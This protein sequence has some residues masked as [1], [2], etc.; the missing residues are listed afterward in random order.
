MRS[1]LLAVVALGGMT[2]RAA[3]GQAPPTDSTSGW[4]L[5]ITPTR[6]AR[7]ATTDGTW[8]SLDVAPDGRRIVFDLVGQLY[9]L[10]ITGGTAHAITHGL[11]WNGQPRFSPD[12]AR[13]VFTSDRSGQQNLWTMRPD[14][15]DAHQLTHSTWNEGIYES[16]AWSPDGRSV[17]VTKVTGNILYAPLDLIRVD[18]ATGAEISV[19]GAMNDGQDAYLGAAFAS[20]L[21]DEVFVVHIRGTSW[22]GG[23]SVE[24]V[25]LNLRT[26]FEGAVR[27]TR[28]MA[29][30]AGFRPAVSHDGHYLAYATEHDSGATGVCLLDR[31]TGADRRLVP[32]ASDHAGTIWAQDLF[33][34][35]AF[36]PDN[37]A[38]VL[39]YG[40]KLHRV[41]VATGADHLIPF[42]AHIDQPIG[43][44]IAPHFAIDDSVI[45]VRG[46]SHPT[47]SPDGRELA[48][49]AVGK[50]WLMDLPDGAPHRLT[51]T[52]RA[53]GPDEFNP[54]W[55]P[56]G[57]YVAYTAWSDWEGGAL[58][59]V[60]V[61]GGP[62]EQLT[63][64]TAR[65][66]SVAYSPDGRWLY[67]DRVPGGATSFPYSYN[68]LE[69]A[70]A[71]KPP[72]SHQLVRVPAEGG[73][74]TVVTRLETR[75]WNPTAVEPHFVD[76]VGDWYFM[77]S[78][79]VLARGSASRT[80][81]DSNESTPVLR[82]LTRGD[83]GPQPD[84]TMFR[85]IGLSIVP[86]PDGR[87]AVATQFPG[88]L[89][90]V[91]LPGPLAAL[92]S[93]GNPLVL[94]VYEAKQPAGVRIQR[95][96]GTGGDRVEWARD[97]SYFVYSAGPVI[98]K[99]YVSRDT[100]AA[101][102]LGRTERIEVRLTLP[103]DLPHGVIALR[104]ARLVTMR[105]HEV[106]GRG[107]LVVRDNRIVALGPT[108]TVAI[109]PDAKI[110]ELA[111]K[112]ILPGYIDVHDHIY[113][114]DHS[115]LPRLPHL[116]GELAYGTTT[117][118]DPLPAGNELA[119][120]HERIA[121]GDAVGPRVFS[122]SQAI[123]PD[124]LWG[125]ETVDAMRGFLKRWS[126]DYHSETIKLIANVG[127][128]RRR[129]LMAMAA[130]AEGLFPTNHIEGQTNMLTTL[131]DGYG[132]LEHSLYDVPV[133]GDVAKLFAASGIVW[134][135]TIGVE[136]QATTFYSR[137]LVPDAK[138]KRFT[139]PRRLDLLFS[140]GE[141]EYV[142]DDAH[143]H[144]LLEVPAKIAAAGGKVGVG[145]H[146]YVIGLSPH[147]EMWLYV[148]GG[149]PTHDA[150]RA[151]TI[152][153]AQEIGHGD[154]LGSLEV[155]KLA[156]LQVL[157]KDPL[158][159]IRNTLSIRY[160][161]KNGRL[162]DASDLTEIWPR[163]KPI[164]PF[165]WWGDSLRTSRP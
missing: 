83:R 39:A 159:D 70:D 133:Y 132:A 61:T 73:P 2:V 153:S 41:D 94:R 148:K 99:Q 165:W 45:R 60:A 130:Q 93:T 102:M 14:G 36:T 37:R 155:G 57:R 122:T 138:L 129:E 151:G 34:G 64:D 121:L 44:L 52:A 87:Y 7:Y 58:Y 16:P 19:T 105:G 13:I 29:L 118:R 140:E 120:Y 42:I 108:G 146:G 47:L 86:S 85:T 8:M 144:H 96:W 56:D 20:P 90:V 77:N 115:I 128:R 117:L 65:Y 17:I 131:L 134:T 35:Y 69:R 89:Y 21:S 150:L 79:S 114:T 126:E 109:P 137:G 113:Y 1:L 147:W 84:G 40:G 149:M 124:V 51:A 9:I 142:M 55:S 4:G 25:R 162:Y 68:D 156:D 100:L 163:H 143:L 43:P 97:G 76:N 53:A 32:R 49:S 123:H 106:I 95:V 107:D 24:L 33:P 30:S 74:P 112:T 154:D 82:I 75:R 10:P 27:G 66:E 18:A 135:P 50:V 139:P 91:R 59:R 46:V 136:F 145:G 5:P 71:M 164:E 12:G 88:G 78:E 3:V 80:P 92:P 141:A 103:A 152:W 101:S 31:R 127:W 157:D 62:A 158:T 23:P 15:S 125:L 116:P 26:R 22:K 111:G 54:V 81:A 119:T 160:V 67:A 104:G 28:T 48:F 6:T 161:M 98:V 72:S 110:F 38:L 11:P 63:R